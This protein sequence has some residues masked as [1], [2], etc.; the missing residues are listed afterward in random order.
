MNLRS[1]LIY[2]L[3][4]T[5]AL[6]ITPVVFAGTDAQ[7]TIVFE[8]K[9]GKVTF[10]HK[11]HFETYY[12]D[13][14]ELFE[15]KS[16]CGDCHHDK[17]NKPLKDLKT[18]DN[19]QKC[20]DCHKKPGYIKGKEARG[21]SDEQKREYVANALHDNCKDCHK[22]YNKD[23]NLKPKDEGYAP[24]TCKTCHEKGK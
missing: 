22:L 10:H 11:K 18:G 8:S 14:P 7:D 23:K 24:N 4:I 16:S 15:S 12:K 13:Y 20:I 1:G 6:G 9:E 19:V 21:L 2:I 3:L 17:D 5:V